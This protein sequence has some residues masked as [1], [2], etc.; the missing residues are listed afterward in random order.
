M[1]GHCPHPDGLRMPSQVVWRYVVEQLPEG[2]ISLMPMTFQGADHCAM[3]AKIARF[4][5]FQAHSDTA[6]YKT[7]R[8]CTIDEGS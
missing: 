8:V 5:L 7:S 4:A 3:T 6:L 2:L 1:L